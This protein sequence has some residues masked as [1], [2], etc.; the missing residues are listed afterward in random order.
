[1]FKINSSPHLH[2][3]KLTS[4]VML[5]VIFAMLPALAVQI[6]FW[7]YGVLFQAAL[8]IS[9]AVALEYA[10]TLLRGKPKL[11]Y[12]RDFSVIL[13]ALILAIAIPPY[14]PYWLILIGIFCS[15]ILAKHIYGGLGQN[16]FNPAMIGYAILLVSFPVQMT[17]WTP[18]IYLL[19]QSISLSDSWTLIF[20][21]MTQE[22]LTQAQLIS[23]IDGITSATSLDAVKNVT[24]SDN[25]DAL[26]SLTRHS[27]I[28]YYETP[29]SIG[30]LE[31]NIAFLIGGIFLMWKKI[32]HWHIPFAFLTALF[33]ISFVPYYFSP[34]STNPLFH[35]FSGATMFGAFFIAT[36]PVSAPITPRGKLIFGGL[37][38]LLVGII[39]YWG[40]YP[41]GVAFAVLLA[42]ICVP[43]IDHYT[44][45]R[46]VG[47]GVKR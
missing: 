9:F 6:Y 28:F 22:G 34:F 32:I 25:I 17:N 31:L 37:I 47:Y 35:L 2:S 30:W 44:R 36:D 40:N 15:V 45:P 18:P 38:G 27:P 11:F 41:D 26:Y 8:A 20:F 4:K 14:A 43:L 13:T 10:V 3:G 12:V 1:M 7:G 16:P 42:N 46:V 33:A 23:T 19:N 21:G 24:R 5:W 29:L 39:R